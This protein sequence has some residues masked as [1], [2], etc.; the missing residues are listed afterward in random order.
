MSKARVWI[1]TKT[2]KAGELVR[3]RAL[4]MH[5]MET[6]FRLDANGQPI[7]RNIIH[8]F[9]VKLNDQLLF[10]WFPETAISQ[11]PYIEFTVRANQAGRLSMQWTD[12]AGQV[13]T[14]DLELSLSA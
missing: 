11:N 9:E 3:V 7:E 2:P 14:D 13:I 6:G 5:R 1:S 10:S 12:D 4:V 8:S